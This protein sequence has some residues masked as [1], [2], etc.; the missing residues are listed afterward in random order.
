MSG[1]RLVARDALRVDREK[2]YNFRGEISS[3]QRNACYLSECFSARE[4]LALVLLAKVR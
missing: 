1:I 3:F 4:I 2:K